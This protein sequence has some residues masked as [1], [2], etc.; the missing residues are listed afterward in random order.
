MTVEDCFIHCFLEKREIQKYELEIAARDIEIGKLN[1]KIIELEAELVLLKKKKPT[2]LPNPISRD[3]LE[4]EY[5]DLIE[6]ERKKK[7]KL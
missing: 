2:E 5:K 7:D 1:D 4:S 3:Y 6:Q